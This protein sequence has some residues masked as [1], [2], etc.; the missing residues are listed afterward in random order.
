MFKSECLIS[1]VEEE[2]ICC[3]RMNM[4]FQLIKSFNLTMHRKIKNLTIENCDDRFVEL[5]Y[6]NETLKS[7]NIYEYHIYPPI[8]EDINIASINNRII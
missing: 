6:Y 8:Y 7:N 5:F 1:C 2:L 3:E 4:D